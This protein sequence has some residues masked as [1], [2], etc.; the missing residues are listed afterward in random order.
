[1]LYDGTVVWMTRLEHASTRQVDTQTI[2]LYIGKGTLQVAS[3]LIN[4]KLSLFAKVVSDTAVDLLHVVKCNRKTDSHCA[5]CSCRNRAL[6]AQWDV[7]NAAE[8]VV[9]KPS[10]RWTQMTQ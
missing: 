10:S 6:Y 2:H 9:R 4:S 5:K 3:N 8:K 1:M 7:G